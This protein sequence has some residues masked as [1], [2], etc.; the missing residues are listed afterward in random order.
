MLWEWL[1]QQRLW[2]L[3]A[4]DTRAAGEQQQQNALKGK[5]YPYTTEKEERSKRGFTPLQ[6][7][8]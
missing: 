5:K 3:V 7:S 8:V 6:A 1:A 2:L 4:F